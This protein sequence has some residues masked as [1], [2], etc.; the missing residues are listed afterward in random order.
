M[1]EIG[2][3]VAVT[4]AFVYEIGAGFGVAAFTG[5]TPTDG[6]TGLGF[7]HARD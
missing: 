5:W 7:L 1:A 6:G 3:A 4:A 2:V